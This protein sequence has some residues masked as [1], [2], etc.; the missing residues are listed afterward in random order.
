[1]TSLTA[2][3][4]S[5]LTNIPPVSRSSAIERAIN[6]LEQAALYSEGKGISDPPLQAK[7]QDFLLAIEQ[8]VHAV[9]SR[10]DRILLGSHAQ[11]GLELLAQNGSLSAIFPEVQ[12]MVGFGDGEWRH[13]DVWKHTK[14]VVAQAVCRLEIRWAALFHDIG[15]TKTRSISPEGKVHFL[16]H[17]EVGARM[18]DK[19]DQRIALFAAHKD[20]A[21]K[22]SIRFLVLHHLRANQ[23]TSSWTD[24]AVRRFGREFAN[25]WDDLLCLSRADITT[26]RPHKKRQGLAQ[27]DELEA[28]V[29]QLRLEDSKVPP[30]PSGIGEQVMLRFGLRP[31]PQVGYIKKALLQAID[32]GEIEAHQ[33][34]DCYIAFIEQHTARFLPTENQSNL[35]QESSLL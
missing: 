30:L 16:G 21:L 14:Q 12:A 35:L 25:H 34:A 20:T 31:S 8:E 5:F 3:S 18:F 26:K 9:R 22:K 24:S 33:S 23:Y 32:L 1:M 19:L 17:A 2:T 11:D 6:V 13:K 7:R 15:K 27:L 29:Y 28:R 4:L 10:L